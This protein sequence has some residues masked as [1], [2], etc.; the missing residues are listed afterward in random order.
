MCNREFGIHFLKGDF[1][2]FYFLFYFFC[3]WEVKLG[4]KQVKGSA[5]RSRPFLNIEVKPNGK[6]MSKNVKTKRVSAPLFDTIWLHIWN[7][8]ATERFCWSKV[9]RGFLLTDQLTHVILKCLDYTFT[10]A[11]P[12]QAIMVWRFH[13]SSG[14]T[15]AELPTHQVWE[16]AAL[17]CAGKWE[18]YVL[19]NYSCQYSDVFDDAGML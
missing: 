11:L 13:E 17:H 12:T 5:R 7:G 6:T 16:D 9:Q 19:W 8:H 1:H 4:A 14:E 2:L 15:W 10:W 18:K 3:G